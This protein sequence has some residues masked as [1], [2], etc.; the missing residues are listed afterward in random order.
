MK[1]RVGRSQNRRDVANRDKELGVFFLSDWVIEMFDTG[2]D[3]SSPTL[4]P[5]HI[6]LKP[7]ALI[8]FPCF[9]SYTHM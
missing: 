8:S 3:L 6:V 4:N 7:R 1:L 5:A 2:P 9:F